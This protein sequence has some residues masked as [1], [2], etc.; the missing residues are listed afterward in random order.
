MVQEIKQWYHPIEKIIKKLILPAII[1]LLF[2]IITEFFFHSKIEPYILYFEILD[3]IIIFIF[4]LDLLFEYLKIRKFWPFIKKSW[5]DIIAIFPFFL[6]FRALERL[7]LV[8]RFGEEITEAQKVLHEGIEIAKEAKLARTTDIVKTESR[9]MRF[10]RPTL[11][12]LRLI[13]GVK[14]KKQIKRDLKSNLKMVQ[15]EQKQIKKNFK[16]IQKSTK[17]VIKKLK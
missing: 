10:L 17:E 5:L 11:R 8:I 16:I 1:I 13:K 12:S 9:F 15:K 4:V 3:G 2:I 7:Y 6:L 14:E